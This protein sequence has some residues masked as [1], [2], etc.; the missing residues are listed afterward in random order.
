M[1]EYLEEN[2]Y[3]EDN[4]Y[5]QLDYLIYQCEKGTDYW[6]KDQNYPSDLIFMNFNN[7]RQ[8]AFSVEIL[9]RVFLWAFE[10]SGTPHEQ[11]RINYAKQ[12]Y[13]FFS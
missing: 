10:K 6:S 2:G 13:S 11:N 12:W 4:L 5:G 9:T 7:F 8:S 3:E 1:F